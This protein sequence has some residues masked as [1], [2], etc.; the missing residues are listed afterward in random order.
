VT[1]APTRP[2]ATRRPPPGGRSSRVWWWTALTGGALLVLLAVHMVAHHFVV[3][4]VGGLRSYRQV[5]DYIANPVIFSI[6]L[7]F[8]V[9]V[10]THALLG[11]RGVLLDLGTG[12]RGRRRI[13]VM[14][15][16]LGIVTVSYGVFLIGTL[17]SRA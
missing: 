1:V 3:Q 12:A 17:A 5:L 10:T 15:W 13:D 9:V 8:L 7:A 11:L 4:D 14:L 6:E 2:R 16:V